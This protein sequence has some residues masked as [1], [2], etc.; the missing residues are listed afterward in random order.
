MK[1]AMLVVVL[2]ILVAFAQGCLSIKVP[3]YDVPRDVNFHV[4]NGHRSDRDRDKDHKDDKDDKDDDD[5]D[6]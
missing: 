3:K 4:N 1:R 5:R 6:R 2:L